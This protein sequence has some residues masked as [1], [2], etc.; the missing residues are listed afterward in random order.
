M[1]VPAR[2]GPSHFSMR[3]GDTMPHQCVRCAS[4]LP[5]PFPEYC[6]RCGLPVSKSLPPVETQQAPSATTHNQAPTLS[7]GPAEDRISSSSAEPAS[8]PSAK[9]L[10]STTM[11]QQTNTW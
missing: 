8:T 11:A 10:A 7:D 4:E 2:C 1:I 6:P 3:R 5:E 9:P